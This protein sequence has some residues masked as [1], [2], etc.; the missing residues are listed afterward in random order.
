VRDLF[1]RQLKVRRPPAPAASAAGAPSAERH[2]SGMHAGAALRRGRPVSEARQASVARCPCVRWAWLPPATQVM[3]IMPP[4]LPRASHGKACATEPGAD[5]P[6]A[7]G[8]RAQVPLAGGDAALA[9]LAAWE[10][11]LPAG[12]AAPELPPPV[13][14]AR[15]KAA[16]AAAARRGHEAAVASGRPAD[17]DLLAAY[18]AYIRLEEVR[19]ALFRLRAACVVARPWPAAA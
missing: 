1:H 19:A 8:A 14:R 5:A 4:A 10:A 12:A 18:M 13:V 15:A 6:E 7:G 3:R 9:A 2:K 11:R 17:A 16:A